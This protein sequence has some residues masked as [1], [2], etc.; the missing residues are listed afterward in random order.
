[1]V[2]SVMT[3]KKKRNVTFW[4]VIFVEWVISRRKNC[5]KLSEKQIFKSSNKNYFI[6]VKSCS[7]LS[8]PYATV[9]VFW[10]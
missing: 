3:C 1:M 8:D 6:L 9:L 4:R 5:D 2:V 10:Q 7:L